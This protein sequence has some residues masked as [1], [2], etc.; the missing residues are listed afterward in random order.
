MNGNDMDITLLEFIPH[1][2]VPINTAAVCA[3]V[4]G[5]ALRP[6][7]CLDKVSMKDTQPNLTMILSLGVNKNAGTA[8]NYIYIYDS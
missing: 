4:I 6:K 5:V 1:L 2:H 8:R 3:G 7:I